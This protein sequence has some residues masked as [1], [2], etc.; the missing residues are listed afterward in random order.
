MPAAPP[1]PPSRYRD[2]D[3][4]AVW[5]FVTALLLWP[6][7]LVLS[8]VAL[9]RIR[10]SGDGGWGLA[11]A[12]AAISTVLA[13]LSAIGAVLYLAGSG[14]PGQWQRDAAARGDAATVRSV[15]QD[16]ASD[17]TGLREDDG[18]W[19]AN[20]REV[21]QEIGLD[22]D[23]AV[24]DVHV[25]AYLDGDALC[26]EGTLETG[27]G[28]VLAS[29]ADGEHRAD[30]GCADR[31]YPVTLHT[32]AYRAE[33][34]GEDAAHEAALTESRER[35]EAAA[36]ESSVGPPKDLGL[37]GT[38]TVDLEACAVLTGNLAHLDDPAVRAAVGELFAAEVEGQGDLDMDNAAYSLSERTA[39]ADDPSS[40]YWLG[41][42]RARHSCWHGGYA[43]PGDPPVFPT[44]W[45]IPVTQEEVDADR[46]LR[47]AIAAGT[48]DPAAVAQDRAEANQEQAEIDAILA[49]YR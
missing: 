8:Y 7:G 48:A 31:G 41:V 32:A 20:L 25:E 14:P 24:R 40:M 11:L 23:G 43:G 22:D 15:T 36:A 29:Y 45:T 4:L 3:P 16:V 47:D 39:E 49:G 10:R 28:A 42:L 27:S 44:S 26:V 37:L 6:A 18:A 35:G 21:A 46:A 1:L 33:A 30:V 2:T 34:A 12:G 5:G 9:R 38:P 13:V 17:L 19:P